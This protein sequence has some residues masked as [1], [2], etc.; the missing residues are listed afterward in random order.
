[1]ASVSVYKL[2]KAYRQYSSQWARLL[3]CIDPFNKSR[4]QLKWVLKDI[5]FEVKAG[6]CVGIL[7]INGA[8]KSTLLKII[9]G[10]SVATSGTVTMTGRV[11][12][13]LELGTGFHPDF[14]GRQN[15]RMAGQLSGLSSAEIDAL[16]P[17]IE[18]FADIG[19]YFDCPIRIY[20][21]GMQARVAFAAATCSRPDVL[22]VDEALSVGDM[23]FQ[24]KCMQRMNN[25]LASG[26]AILF[27]SHALNQVRQFCA[28]ALYISDGTIKAWGS[29][30]EVC[31]IYQNDLVGFP[32]TD[33][34]TA[35]INE[36]PRLI[37]HRDAQPDPDLRK[38]SVAGAAG[39]TLDLEFLN[40]KVH[41]RNGDRI[42]TCRTGQD[43]VFKAAII[44]NKAVPAGAVVGL[45]FADKTGYHIMACNTNY[46]DKFL[47]KL[48]KGQIAFVSWEVKVPF[49][50]G[51][52]RIDSGIK[53]DPFSTHFYD[54]V[55]C[56]ATLS[57][58]TEVAL[59]KK[60]FGGYLHIDTN[61]TIEV[62]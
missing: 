37:L 32:Q 21:S 38:H 2:G 26:T 39:G 7:G 55:F 60:N 9:S 40:F 49:A 16:M 27:V 35:P 20:S 46:Y 34:E 13:L 62:I 23:A 18:S 14:T 3:D 31:D 52:F 28:R 4:S 33:N 25:L 61:I 10:T 36:V 8:G 50:G 51:E 30:E 43:I 15:A 24:A 44:A 42:A 48:E 19:D 6:E 12:A 22:I 53:P 47:P 45:L 11:A 1:M 29:A 57:V 41:S 54:I 17:E 58:A 59:L 5:S 56:L